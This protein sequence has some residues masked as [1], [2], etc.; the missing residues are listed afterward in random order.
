MIQRCA[1]FIFF[2]TYLTAVILL[3]TYL[4]SLVGSII[5]VVLLA[6]WTL[7]WLAQSSDIHGYWCFKL[8]AIFIFLGQLGV[9][10]W[11]NYLVQ[12]MSV[13]GSWIFQLGVESP[14]GASSCSADPRQTTY[15]Y[16]PNGR[17]NPSPYSRALF[18]PHASICR[19]GDVN[20]SAPPQGY[21]EKGD[22][23][24]APDLDNPCVVGDLG[25]AQLATDRKQDYPDPGTGLIHGLQ[26]GSLVTQLDVCPDVDRF[27]IQPDGE[28][29]G[30]GLPVCAFCSAY[31]QREHKVA[32]EC[33]PVPGYNDASCFL[34]VDVSFY[35]HD[36]FQRKG[37]AITFFV[38]IWVSL[39]FACL[40]TLLTL[41]QV[42]TQHKI[43]L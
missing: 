35:Q 19:W 4:Q 5:A 36:D 33:S 18:C 26:L 13:P 31:M 3:M 9:F 30:T 24:Y 1:F 6:L 20:A 43:K 25:C 2:V 40:N 27:Q 37:T 29:L 11:M 23:M 42:K 12:E 17:F 34:C 8:M 41:R 15:P 14:C 16:N 22:D 21:A 28:T 7:I 39:V 32:T 38:L 10:F